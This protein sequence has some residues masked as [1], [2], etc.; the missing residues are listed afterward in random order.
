MPAVTGS[1][2]S[3][4]RRVLSLDGGGVRGAV[5]LAFLEE[6]EAALARRGGRVV[7]LCDHFDLIGGTSTGAII[8]TGLA[9]G[10]S[11]AE[12]RAFYERLGPKVFRRSPWRILGLQSKFGSRHLMAELEGIVGDRTLGSPDLQT[13]LAIVTKRLD[14]GSPWVLTNNPASAF[15]ETPA[16]G[17]FVGN[18]HFLLKQIVR[19]SAAAPHFFDPQTIEIAPGMPAGLFVDGGVTPY[20]NPSVL[21]LKVATLPQF[22]LGFET[23][24]DRLEIVSVG[25]GGF[26]ERLPPRRGPRPALA[27]ALQALM[28][29]IADAQMQ[30]LAL[31]SWLGAS[32]TPW[33]INSEL[34][35]LGMAAG[36]C[37]PLFSFERY[38]VLLEREWLAAELGHEAGE[39]E[40]AKLR[41]M[42]DPR[43]IPTL[44]QLGRRAAARQIARVYGA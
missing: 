5:S 28:G 4:P 13:R 2:T 34:G 30:S 6:L 19:A 9:L 37:A 40:V 25:T 41:E 36:P 11:A 21:L 27:I 33:E 10:Y 39:K 14:T 18:R 20:N 12:M 32:R 7:R 23:G 1:P 31:M 38:D 16:D 22:G 8:A 26:R 42:D 3:T 29:Q 35:D 17:S 15:W 44:Y 24:A 43:L